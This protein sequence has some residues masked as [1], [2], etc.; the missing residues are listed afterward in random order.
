M[1]ETR[2]SYVIL[3][4]RCPYEA[5]KSGL[6]E[7]MKRRDTTDTK[8]SGQRRSAPSLVILA[9][10]FHSSGGITTSLRAG[11]GRSVLLSANDWTFVPESYRKAKYILYELISGIFCVS[12]FYEVFVCPIAVGQLV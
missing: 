3:T 8:R 6:P 10:C 7:N 5:H 9:S 4:K 12:E 1:T 2:Y 11:T